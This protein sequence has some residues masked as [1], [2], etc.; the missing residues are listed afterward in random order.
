MM[1]KFWTVLTLG[2]VLAAPVFGASDPLE[3]P[4]VPDVVA[5]SSRLPDA[6]GAF[7]IT[8]SATA[9][10][11]LDNGET[12]VLFGYSFVRDTGRTDT[13]L[14][15]EANNWSCR[16]TTFRQ[17]DGWGIG[18]IECREGDHAVFIH[19]EI[20]ITP[21]AYRYSHATVK[22]D[23]ESILGQPYRAVFGWAEQAF[24]DASKL[25]RLA[26]W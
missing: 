15:N 12:V 22:F 26:R 13:I 20:K 8:L 4:P 9:V 23:G 14:V 25:V 3:L 17:E 11:Q 24:P 5:L 10:L 1:Q 7:T 6:T 16:T 19:D 21:R 18:D 2:V